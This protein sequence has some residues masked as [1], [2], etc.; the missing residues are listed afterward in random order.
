MVTSNSNNDNNNRFYGLLIQDNADEQVRETIGH[1]TPSL[2]SSLS[3]SNNKMDE[4]E[5]LNLVL[6]AGD[7]VVIMNPAR[8][9]SGI[10]DSKSTAISNHAPFTTVWLSC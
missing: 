2:L 4:T 7:W 8:A 10:G 9:N 3:S 1:T 6:L 5:N